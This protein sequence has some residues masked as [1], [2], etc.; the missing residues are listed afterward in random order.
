M[1]HLAI[2]LMLA[3]SSWCSNNAGVSQWYQKK[4]NNTSILAL[5]WM[6]NSGEYDALCLQAFSLAKLRFDQALAKKHN[7]P[8]AVVVDVDETIVDN[9]PFNAGLVGT[10]KSYSSKRWNQWVRAEQATSL[11]GS[12]DF[13]KHV[14]KSGAEVF[15]IT[16]RSEDTRVATAANLKALGFPMVDD[17]HLIL[18]TTTSSKIARRAKVAKTHEIVLLMG[19]SL[20][21]FNGI[22]E[23]KSKDDRKKTVK[24]HSTLFGT[25]FIVLPNP[26]YGAW[27][28]SIYNYKNIKP[29]Q[30]LKTLKKM[31]N[32]F[33]TQ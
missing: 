6:Q 3:T 32:G 30:K 23:H 24:N 7:K 4:L 14:V 9:M 5:N 28:Q 33:V 25:K 8:I 2:I 18:K 1:K 12:V 19:D 31:L 15:Y 10:T 16:N 27:E 17:T 21:D 22:F 29:S 11:E 26:V 20:D 13:F